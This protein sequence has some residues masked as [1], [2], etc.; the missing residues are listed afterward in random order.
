MKTYYLVLLR[1]GQSEW[2]KENRFT[3]WTDIGLSEQGK[4]EAEKA[5]EFLK[6]HRYEF[7][8]GYTSVLKRANDTLEIILNKMKISLP[9]EKH[10]RL[11]E[12][13]YGALQGINKDE[14]RKKY[15]EEQVQI[16]RRSYD[17]RPPALDENDPRHPKF[18]PKYKDLSPKDLP[19]TE[20]LKDTVLRMMPFIEDV[21]IPSITGGKKIIVAAHGNSLRA[22]VKY[23]EH[24]S[25]EEI[26]KV[27][28]PTGVPL[29]YKL[30][31]NLK[32]LEKFYIES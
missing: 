12:R 29:I 4:K 23:L 26:P 24:I 28:I 19:A 13:H 18:D 8:L 14:M 6:K 11:N 10:W 16:W 30:D 31:E 5:G 17:I 2:N 9:I 32:V 20:S 25:D 3:G 7:D 21:L 22:L 27:E 15:G 1:H